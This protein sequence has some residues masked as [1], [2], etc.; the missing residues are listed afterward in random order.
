MG[1]VLHS[2][3]LGETISPSF[4]SGKGE[5]DIN[6]MKAFILGDQSAETQ[7]KPRLMEVHLKIYFNCSI[8][9]SRTQ[10]KCLLCWS[11]SLKYTTSEVENVKC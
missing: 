2:R 7:T 3:V 10:T 1:G 6:Q 5:D 11:H 8:V 4:S 9:I